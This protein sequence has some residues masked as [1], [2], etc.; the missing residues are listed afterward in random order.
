LKYQG[1][2]KVRSIIEEDGLPKQL[3][4]FDGYMGLVQYGPLMHFLVSEKRER[5]AGPRGW[6]LVI[7]ASKKEFFLVGDNFQLY[8]RAKPTVKMLPPALNGDWRN[9]SLGT[10]MSVEEGHFDKNGEFVAERR[11]NGD[12]VTWCGLWAEPNCGVVRAITCD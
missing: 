3:F 10:F 6:G 9:T 12:Q 2:G 5:P 8:L 4:D 1:T 11:R 7:Q